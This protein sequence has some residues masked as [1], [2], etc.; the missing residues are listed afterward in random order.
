MSYTDQKYQ[1]NGEIIQHFEVK[2]NRPIACNNSITIVFI[3]RINAFLH[4]DGYYFQTL[5]YIIFFNNKHFN[6]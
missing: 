4:F 5:V 3:N 6:K 2:I 1:S